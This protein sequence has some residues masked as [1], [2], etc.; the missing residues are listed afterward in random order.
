MNQRRSNQEWLDEL[1]GQRGAERQQQAHQD[2]A[3]FVFVVGYN[4]LLKRQY[5]NSAP[6]IQHYLPEDL[7]ALAEDH[8]QEIL[9]KLTANDYARLNSYNATGRFTGWVAVITRNHIASALRLIFFDHPHDNIEEIIDL[10]TQD[11]DPT[12]QAALREIWDELS[13]C[14]HRLIDRRQHA[15][16]RSVIENAPTITIANEL[17][18]TESAVHQLVMH[19]RRNLRDCMMAKGFGP[20]MLELFES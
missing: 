9:I 15:F 19:A 13:D 16:R 12:T 18:C 4:Y 17:E 1:R 8:T 11:L 2:L 5:T 10:P 20:D 3:D 7:A 14:I 6:A